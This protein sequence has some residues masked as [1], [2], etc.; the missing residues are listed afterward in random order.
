MNAVAWVFSLASL[1]QRGRKGKEGK[2]HGM[3]IYV[4]SPPLP[5]PPSYT[6]PRP[7]SPTGRWLILFTA[8]HQWHT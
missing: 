1:L 8:W 2:R 6:H 3:H 7:S 5:S 4:P